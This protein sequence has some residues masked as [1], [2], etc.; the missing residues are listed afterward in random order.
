LV[1]FY[2]LRFFKVALGRKSLHDKKTDSHLG[3][4]IRLIK[5]LKAQWREKRFV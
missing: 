5:E 1:D 2:L 3:G 4:G